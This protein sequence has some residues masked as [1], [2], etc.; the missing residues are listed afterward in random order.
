MD[1]HPKVLHEAR[2][3]QINASRRYNKA[4]MAL[5]MGDEIQAANCQRTAARAARTAREL[6]GIEPSDSDWVKRLLS[7]PIPKPV[8]D[9]WF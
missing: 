5:E 4:A 7:M 9:T 8:D 3:N 6:L 1:P 2:R